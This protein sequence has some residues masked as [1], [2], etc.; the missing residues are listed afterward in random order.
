MHRSRARAVAGLKVAKQV[1]ELSFDQVVIPWI[2]RWKGW[3][4]LPVDVL[5]R[6]QVL[7]E[8]NLQHSMRLSKLRAGGG[9]AGGAKVGEGFGVERE[10]SRWLSSGDGGG[11]CSAWRS[12]MMMMS[13]A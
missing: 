6:R 4:R 13:A 7:D 2:A 10:T 11:M 8:G 12:W 5:L 1:T 3:E 9:G